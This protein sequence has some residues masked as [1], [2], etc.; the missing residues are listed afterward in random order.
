MFNSQ[1]DYTKY[2]WAI[3]FKDTHK[4]QEYNDSNTILMIV[5]DVTRLQ[6]YN[7]NLK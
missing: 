7:H 1:T 2:I 6:Q 4:V 3:H 5:H